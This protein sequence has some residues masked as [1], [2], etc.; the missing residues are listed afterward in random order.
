MTKTITVPKELFREATIERAEGMPL[1]QGRVSISSDVPYLRYNWRDDEEYYEVLDHGPGGMDESRL[2]AGLPIHFNHDR[3]QHMG[4]AT[5]YSN[6]GKK[7][8]TDA[9]KFIWASGEWAENKRADVRSGALPTTSVGYGIANEGTY[10]GKAKDGIP[11]YKF[12]WVPHE[13][14][15]VTIPAD[16]TVGAGRNHQREHKNDDELHEVVVTGEIPVDLLRE[17]RKNNTVSDT[18]TSNDMKFPK[19]FHEADKGNNP[20]GGGGTAAV[21]VTRERGDAVRLERERVG[22]IDGYVA[23]FKVEGMRAKVTDLAKQAKEKGTSYDEFRASV[24]DNWDQAK[25]VETPDP[26]IGMSKRDRRQYSLCKAIR[27]IGTG[28]Q[29]TG[30]EKEASEAAQKLAGREYSGL[31]IPDDIA[32]SN[33]AEDND[34]G[35]RAIEA[36]IPYLREMIRQQ[37]FLNAST[38]ASGGYLVGTELLT[39]SII[40][41]L[42]NKA[43]VQGLGATVL[44]GLTGNIAIPKVTG[45]AS[46]YWLAEGAQSTESDQTFAQLGLSPKRLGADSAYT[47]QLVAQASL[48]VEAFVRDDIAKQMAVEADRVCIAGLGSQGQPLGILNTPGVQVLTFGGAPTYAALVEFE[49]LIEISNAMLGPHRLPDGPRSQGHPQDDPANQPDGVPDLPAAK[50]PGRQRHQR[51]QGGPHQ[52]LPGLCHKQRPGQ[53]HDRRRLERTDDRHVGRHRRGGGPLQ[54]Q[55][56]RTD[57]GHRPPVHGP[58]RAPPGFLRGFDRFRGPVTHSRH[59]H[60]IHPQ[61]PPARLRKGVRRQ[62]RGSGGG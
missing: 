27:E 62:G 54:P 2:K 45:G 59:A 38:G 52:R 37:R 30:L 24:L 57:R 41:L 20:D 40:E 33:L 13:F 16:I 47:K 26:K 7:L 17:N 6:D 39:G 9:S 3:D 55:A 8:T 5:D 44:S 22:Q 58:R 60:P 10:M 61:R 34:L 14:S 28:G 21:D 51:R 18:A 56:G 11:I 29:L 43:L 15:F 23:S 46:T 35:Q 25:A 42:R 53:P 49:T 31:T 12:K 19:R 48:S 4:R 36:Q 50:R 1:D 32:T